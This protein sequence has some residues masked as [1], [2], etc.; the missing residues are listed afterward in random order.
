M[1]HQITGSIIINTKGPK[2]ID[3]T[4]DIKRWLKIR[5]CLKYRKL[6]DQLL[7]KQMKIVK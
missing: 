5:E 1:I 3:I 4:D 7:Q 2:L 6:Q